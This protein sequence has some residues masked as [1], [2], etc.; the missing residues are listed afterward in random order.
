MSDDLEIADPDELLTRLQFWQMKV[1]SNENTGFHM[2]GHNRGAFFS[3]AFCQKLIQL[4]NTELTWSEDLHK[5]GSGLQMITN[6]ISSIYGSAESFLIS[7]GSTTGIQVMISS[8]L[9]KGSFFLLP[10]TV[11]MS[12]IH[13]FML[14]KCE[15]AFIPQVQ[16]DDDYFLFPQISQD[17]L[18]NALQMYPMATD[19]FLVSPDYYGQ[20]ANLKELAETAHQHSCRLLVD[21]AHGAHFTFQKALFPRDAMSSG[22]DMCVQSLHKTMPALT[23]SSLIHISETGISN[24]GI[25]PGR[26]RKCL[27]IFETSSPSFS[28]AASS[29]FAVDWLS[30][31]QDILAAQCKYIDTLVDMSAELLGAQPVMKIDHTKKDRLR[32][33]LSTS[34]VGLSSFSIQKEME[35]EGVY[36]EF[37][38][39]TRLVGIV[40]PWQK[41]EDYDQFYQVLHRI[42]KER[43]NKD[44]NALV[45]LELEK[46][47]SDLALFVPERRIRLPDTFLM[48]TEAVECKIEVAAEQ[49]AAEIIAPYPPGIPLLWPGE[50]ISKEHV[51]FLGIA[52]AMGMEIR[53]V[54]KGCVMILDEYSLES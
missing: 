7:T 13:V 15:Y 3:A 4:D 36:I 35:K 10:R 27:Q 2:P 43:K 46:K 20:A 29:E 33:V 6:R 40:S 50:K 12:V 28:I 41:K 54:H 49:V 38:D 23:M 39:F 37:S 21:E 9:R 47:W 8:V 53:G 1:N 18:K 34:H 30:K 17:D 45:L 48:S 16:S 11:H 51:D 32:I 5:P 44:E 19:I 25:S 26:V 42:I 22:A 14:C 31:N 52:D 24:G